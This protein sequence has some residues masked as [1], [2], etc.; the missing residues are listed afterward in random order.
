MIKHGKILKMFTNNVFYPCEFFMK[1]NMFWLDSKNWLCQSINQYILYL[2]R[3]LILFFQFPLILVKGI[4]TSKWQVE[5]PFWNIYKTHNHIQERSQVFLHSIL[6]SWV[7]DTTQGM[8]LVLVN[9]HLMKVICLTHMFNPCLN[10]V[11]TLKVIF[12][13]IQS[14][15][16]F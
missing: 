10:H 9:L 1:Y 11:V 5:G 14:N 16:D 8:L 6:I 2:L 4:C 7:K 13:V 3:F 12:N 15:C